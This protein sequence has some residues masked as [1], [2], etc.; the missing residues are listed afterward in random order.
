MSEYPRCRYCGRELKSESSRLR[1]YGPECSRKHQKYKQ[2]DLL[3]IKEKKNV[4]T[5]TKKRLKESTK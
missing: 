5:Q 4:T 3:S 2:I 1:G